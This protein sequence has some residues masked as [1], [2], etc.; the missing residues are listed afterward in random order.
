MSL[1]YAFLNIFIPG[2]LQLEGLKKV[3]FFLV[4]S[5]FL[6]NRYLNLVKLAKILL[7]FCPTNYYIGKFNRGSANKNGYGL[8]FTC[9]KSVGN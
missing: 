7:K 9:Y 2:W 1:I 8:I 4:K 6:L 3:G 5:L